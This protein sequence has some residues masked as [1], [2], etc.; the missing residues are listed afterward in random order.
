MATRTDEPSCNSCKKSQSNVPKP[1]KRCAKCQKALYCSQECQRTDWPSHKQFCVSRAEEEAASAENYE[2]K[3]L[4]RPSEI[5]NPTIWRTLSCPAVATFEQLHRALQIAFGWATTHS[6]DFVVKDPDYKPEEHEEDV[7]SMIQRFTATF[8]RGRQSHN[9]PRENL[10]RIIAKPLGG[11]GA[12]DDMYSGM[13]SHPQTP[14]KRNDKLKLYE[15]LEDARYRGRGL[16]YEYDFGDCWTHA[17]TV[18]GRTDHSTTFSCIAGE[19]HPC[20]EDAGGATGWKKLV[21]AY[22]TARPDEEQREKKEW[23]ETQCSNRDRQGLAGE[24]IKQWDK[25]LV[26][27]MLVRVMAEG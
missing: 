8:Q 19:G 3:V 1:L 25:G 18:I 12:V 15:I 23:F 21:E 5:D 13:R 20:A 26:N 4:L 14:E 24:R 10:L 22:R 2:F 9:A 27:R 16:E 7:N 17:I 6:Y 11:F